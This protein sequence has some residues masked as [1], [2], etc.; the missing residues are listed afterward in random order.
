MMKLLMRINKPSVILLARSNT[1]TTGFVTNL[2]KTISVN[3]P[4]YKHTSF[5]CR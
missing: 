1:P 3:K 4:L 2:N 5:K